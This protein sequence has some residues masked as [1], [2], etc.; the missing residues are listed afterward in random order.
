MDF[1]LF[2]ILR[3]VVTIILYISIQFNREYA[4]N[5]VRRITRGSSGTVGAIIFLRLCRTRFTYAGPESEKFK[6]NISLSFEIK[7]YRNPKLFYKQNKLQ[8]SLG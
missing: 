3:T 7:Y 4:E 6:S 5:A 2:I 1:A 8:Q